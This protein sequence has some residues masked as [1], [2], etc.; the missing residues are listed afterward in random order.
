MSLIAACSLRRITLFSGLML[1]ASFSS[2][3]APLEATFILGMD[4][5]GQRLNLYEGCT[6]GHV[7]CDDMLLVAPDLGQLLQTKLLNERLDKSP[8]AIKLYPAKT[9]HSLCKD[10]VTPCGFQGYTFKGED[11]NGLIDP[12][13]NELYITSNW[14][15]DSDTFLYTENRTYLPLVSQAKLIDTMYKTSDQAL[16]SSY[17]NTRQAVRRLYGKQMA[18]DLKQEQLQWIKQRSK[19]CGADVKHQPRTQAEKVCF[20]QQNDTREQAWFLWID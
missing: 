7:T 6:E 3:V 16:N 11:F 15:T 9:K 20:I 1:A 19:D 13:N 8:Y 18:D 17:T 5:Q 12:L 4:I 2:A 10:G 14:T